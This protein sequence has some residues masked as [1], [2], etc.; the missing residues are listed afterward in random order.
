MILARSL[1]VLCLSALPA[2]AGG[3]LE[4]RL[5]TLNV[6]TYD[7]PA[8]PIL[9]SRGQTVTVGTG[10]EFGMGPEFQ[11][12]DFDVVPVQVEIGPT[13]IAFSYGDTRGNFYDAAFNGYVLRF[14]V[15]CA[16]FR[17][18]RIDTE[19]TTLPVTLADIRTEAG[20]LFVNVAGL[21]YG[22]ESTLALDF[23]IDECL[24]G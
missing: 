17:S 13:R 2:V 1:A 22:P 14:E 15:D 5:V 3:S 16:L 9:E 19:A 12:P 23:E 8:M 4:G 6:L 21:H 11:R 20:A 24:M 10:V 7:D 18:V